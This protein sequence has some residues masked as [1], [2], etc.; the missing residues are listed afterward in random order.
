MQTPSFRNRDKQ[1]EP[2]L[3]FDEELSPQ[4]G[5]AVGHTVQAETA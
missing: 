3:V 5:D 1:S 4:R 2:A